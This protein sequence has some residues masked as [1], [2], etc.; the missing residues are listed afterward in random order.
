[1]TGVNPGPC[2]MTAMIFTFALV[3]V[4]CFEL[5]GEHGVQQQD[6]ARGPVREIAVIGHGEGRREGRITR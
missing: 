4:S 3:C 2:E 6:T 5:H 1:M